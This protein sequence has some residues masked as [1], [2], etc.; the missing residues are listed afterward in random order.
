MP[1]IAEFYDY[2]SGDEINSVP[3]SHKINIAAW[4]I[5]GKIYKPVIAV[6]KQ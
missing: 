5:K 4:L 1:T 2:A 3:E 6:R